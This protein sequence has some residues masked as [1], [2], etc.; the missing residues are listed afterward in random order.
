MQVVPHTV[1]VL[2]LIFIDNRIDP[3]LRD[4]RLAPGRGRQPIVSRCVP[5]RFIIDPSGDVSHGRRW[6]DHRPRHVPGGDGQARRR[7]A[8]RLASD[9]RAASPEGQ[10]TTNQLAGK[11]LHGYRR[12][13]T[14]PAFPS[15]G[16]DVRRT[17]T[18]LENNNLR[19]YLHPDKVAVNLTVIRAVACV[20]LAKKRN[21]TPHQEPPGRRCRQSACRSRTH[22]FLYQASRV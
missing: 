3:F 5:G 11:T 2:R 13:K 7:T 15:G 12:A 14:V 1:C 10:D 18:S 6:K 9:Q 16:H 22:R 17:V 19:R 4:R 21:K 8:R 20:R